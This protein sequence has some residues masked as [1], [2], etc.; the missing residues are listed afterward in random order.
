MKF[1][2]VTEQDRA[3]ARDLRR[4]FH[5]IPELAYKENETAGRIANYLR[6][7]GLEVVEN[8][9]QTGLIATLKGTQKGDRSIMIRADYRRPAN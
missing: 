4:E 2:Y 7:I 5:Q 8:I 6:Q 3:A 9:G 1:D